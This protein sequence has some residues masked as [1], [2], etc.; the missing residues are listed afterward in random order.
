MLLG[1]GYWN[2]G[3]AGGFC[4]NREDL[5]SRPPLG[6]VENRRRAADHQ[7][8]ADLLQRSEPVKGDHGGLPVALERDFHGAAEPLAL[9]IPTDAAPQ[10]RARNRSEKRRHQRVLA[11]APQSGDDRIKADHCLEG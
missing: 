8:G 7:G 4:P 10:V 5:P 3:G 11:K 1:N 9:G 2:V 6:D